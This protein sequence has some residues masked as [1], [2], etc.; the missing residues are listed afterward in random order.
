M[1]REKMM[2]D[3]VVY[4]HHDNE[5]RSHLILASCAVDDFKA[6]EKS[7]GE[8]LTVIGSLRDGADQRLWFKKWLA[9][10]G[11]F[12]RSPGF[13]THELGLSIDFDFEDKKQISWLSENSTKFNFYNDVKS[14]PWHFT[15][16]ADGKFEKLGFV[17]YAPYEEKV[18]GPTY[19]YAC[20]ILNE[21]G[22][23]AV[24]IKNFEE[25]NDELALMS[26][27]CDKVLFLAHEALL[28]IISSRDFVR[29]NVYHYSGVLIDKYSAISIA[30]GLGYPTVKSIIN[31]KSTEDIFNQLGDTI[32]Q[33]PREHFTHR[34]KLVKIKHEGDDI[35]NR[36][37]WMYQ[38]Y[39]G[40]TH[41][42]YDHIRVNAL[43][44]VPIMYYGTRNLTDDK[45]VLP[46]GM[47][48]F[49]G[50]V[51]NVELFK[52]DDDD[53]I[54]RE[55]SEL[56]ARI[57]DEIQCGMIGVDVV[58]DGDGRYSIVEVNVN[59]IAIV[60]NIEEFDS[61]ISRGKLIAAAALNKLSGLN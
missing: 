25:L 60:W 52:I 35:S 1:A 24:S 61:R 36:D 14:E 44:G 54:V 16:S 49:K 30:E 47:S 42:P 53:P 59:I 27:A 41:P 34:G 8:E 29:D 21:Q 2:K 32:V 51:E 18:K 33:K 19:D 31:P 17:F 23:S 43:F 11:N 57:S 6:M 58:L 13:S 38:S 37:R 4:N 5:I 9:G 26:S 55:C 46:F 10:E 20:R 3:D 12:A 15:H 40:R 39:G 28:N 45:I 7:F 50:D 22:Y 48:I 56:S